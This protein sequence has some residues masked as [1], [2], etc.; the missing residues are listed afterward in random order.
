MKIYTIFCILSLC[1]F[2][3]SSQNTSQIKCSDRM[4]ELIIDNPDTVIVQVKG[5]VCSSCS[6]GIRIGLAKIDG[7]DKNRFNKGI[8]LDSSNQYVLLAYEL[9]SCLCIDVPKL[10]AH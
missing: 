1:L 8:L 10:S 5:L 2:G 6:I 4:K 3:Y 7:L 9:R